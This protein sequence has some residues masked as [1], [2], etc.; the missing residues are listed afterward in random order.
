MEAQAGERGARGTAFYEG[1]RSFDHHHRAA[2]AGQALEPS[3]RDAVHGHTRLDLV[4]PHHELRVELPAG[5]PDR[6]A[7]V[8]ERVAHVCELPV[9]QRRDAS[10]AG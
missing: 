3:Q 8:V 7:E 10:I 9:E 2:D 4:G 5:G 1:A 6:R